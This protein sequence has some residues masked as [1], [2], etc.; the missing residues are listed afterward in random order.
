MLPLNQDLKPWN[1]GS[2]KKFGRKFLF[3]S[4]RGSETVQL[5]AISLDVPLVGEIGYAVKMQ[6]EGHSID[7][8]NLRNMTR[9]KCNNFLLQVLKQSVNYS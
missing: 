4:Y 1:V 5:R 7:S 3:G 8:C 2:P 9:K 6:Q